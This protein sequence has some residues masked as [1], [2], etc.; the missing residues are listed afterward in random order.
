M[1]VGP[2][3]E[4]VRGTG[5]IAGDESWDR[6][7][8]YSACSRSSSRS[9]RSY[10]FEPGGGTEGSVKRAPDSAMEEEDGPASGSGSRTSPD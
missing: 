7:R 4:G 10:E 1:T 5:M 9:V 2:E 3:A 6:R 8:A